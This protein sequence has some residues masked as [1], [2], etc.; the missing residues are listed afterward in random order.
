MALTAQQTTLTIL[1]RVRDPGGLGHSTTLAMDLLSR[2]QQL[3]SA[4]KNKVLAEG[5]LATI[6]SQLFYPILANFP[7]AIRLTEIRE[8]NRQLDFVPFREFCY[9]KTDWL[10]DVGDYHKMWSTIGHDLLILYPAVAESH[11]LT[12][13]YTKLLDEVTAPAQTFELSDDEMLETMEL[14]EILLYLRS[15]DFDSLNKLIPRFKEH[16]S[17]E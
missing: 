16:L 9:F 3:I 5:T 1:R 7:G 10:R 17:D 12:V 15:R 8:G 11:S 4:Q 6:D 2:S 13:E 14:T